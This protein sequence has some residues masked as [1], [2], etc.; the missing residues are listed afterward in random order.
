MAGV[1]SNTLQD[2]THVCICVQ[3]AMIRSMESAVRYHI[4]NP[5]LNQF[6]K[7]LPTFTGKLC[8]LVKWLGNGFKGPS[9]NALT[10]DAG[11]RMLWAAMQQ[12]LTVKS[13]LQN[14][15]DALIYYS[16]SFQHCRMHTVLNQMTASAVQD[17]VGQCASKVA[18]LT[19]PTSQ[20]KC[21]TSYTITL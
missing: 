5:C 17:T 13:S 3:R 20:Q 11:L 4:L 10:T 15:I 18:T 8:S 21:L 7:Q 9:K 16:R 19:H 6:L 2:W 1:H 14:P 12:L